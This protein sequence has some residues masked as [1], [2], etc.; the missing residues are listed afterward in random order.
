MKVAHYTNCVSVLALA[1]AIAVGAP[2]FAQDA[3]TT[4]PKAEEAQGLEV[5]VVTASGR[6]RTQLNSSVSVTSIGA[7]AIADFKPSSESELLRMIPGIQ[8]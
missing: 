3:T 1:T 4:A 7:E 2:A 8:V 5:I 6:N